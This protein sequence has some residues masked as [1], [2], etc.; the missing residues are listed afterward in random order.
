MTSQETNN[1]F[2][3]SKPAIYKIVVQ[4]EVNDDF[5]RRLGGMQI[6]IERKSGRSPVSVLIGKLSDQAALSGILN[7]LYELD[8]PVVSVQA[9]E[10][11]DK[12]H[13]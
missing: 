1:N 11:M 13:K 12:E 10:E 3:F 2:Q 7:A 5:S 6:T 8:L 9:L 4:G